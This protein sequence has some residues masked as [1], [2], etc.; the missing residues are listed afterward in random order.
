MNHRFHR[1][2]VAVLGLVAGAAGLGV[3]PAQAAG[4]RP[5][6]QLP[7]P[8]GESWRLQTYHDHGDYD[9]DMFYNDGDERGRSILASFDGTVVGAGYQDGGAGWNVAIDHGGG[10]RTAYMHMRES[11]MVVMGQVVLQGQ[12][13]ER[14][15][16]TGDSSND[17]LHYEQW[18]AGSK[19]ESWFN[20]VPSG[21]TSDG[22]PNTGPLYIDG[23]M[24]SPVDRISNNCASAHDGMRIGTLMADGSALA[25][26]GPLN[27][28]WVTERSGGV[29]QF[30]VS[31]DRVATLMSD[32]A[33]LFKDGALNAGWQQVRSAGSTVTAIAVTSIR[34]ATLDAGGAVQVKE[35]P[36]SAAWQAVSS[37]GVKQIALSG[38]RIGILTTAGAAYVKEGAP[39]AAW[40]T[41]RSAGVTHL[42]LG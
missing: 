36:G 16:S 33:V 34:I 6:F 5:L 11:P 20:G 9:I 29:R 12:Q 13:L 19:V 27:A 37:G 32:G 3:V 26:Q 25:K 40:T 14:V 7:F 38:N 30:V 41:Q 24:S 21:I 4:P 10:W 2:A 15:G 8:C 18:R 31:G 35:D 42:T 1:V 28:S 17:H 23:P 39:N 22:N